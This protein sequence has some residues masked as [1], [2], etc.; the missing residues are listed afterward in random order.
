MHHPAHVPSPCLL[1][2][3]VAVSHGYPWPPCPFS[4]SD[5]VPSSYVSLNHV[6][7]PPSMGQWSPCLPGSL[8]SPLLRTNSNYIKIALSLQNCLYVIR[9]ACPNGYISSSACPKQSLFSVFSKPSPLSN[10]P[11]SA[12]DGT[13]QAHNLG[14]KFDCALALP[15]YRYILWFLPSYLLDLS[16][17]YPR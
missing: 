2:V 17:S 4:C 3:C 12:S 16:P 13:T 5:Y 1:S 6:L 7:P 10:F 8:P 15:P 11:I 9:T 14:V